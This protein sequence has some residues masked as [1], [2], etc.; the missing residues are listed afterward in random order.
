LYQRPAGGGDSE[1]DRIDP[2]P[3]DIKG[4]EKVCTDRDYVNTPEGA[5]VCH[6]IVKSKELDQTECTGGDRP[7]E[8]R[9]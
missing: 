5:L 9:W 1:E 8:F 2:K 3:K 4:Q 6:N 7:W